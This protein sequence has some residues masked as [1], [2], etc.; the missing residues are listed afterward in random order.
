MFKSKSSPVLALIKGILVSYILTLIVF[1]VFALLIT[2]TEVS[3]KHLYT[4]IRVTTAVVCILCGLI[5]AGSAKKGGLLWGIFA[6]II[7]VVI[8]CVIGFVLIPQYS[9]TSKFSVSL[10]VAVAGGGLGGVIGINLNR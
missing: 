3:E 1:F 8:M 4:V 9:I 7:Y 2:Y 5:T 6:G 10:I